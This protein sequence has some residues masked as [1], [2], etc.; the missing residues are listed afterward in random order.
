[1]VVRFP[2]GARIF[3]L[4]SVQTGFGAP[5]QPPIQLPGAHSSDVNRPGREAD[6]SPLSS[7]EVKNIGATPPLVHKSSW[8]SA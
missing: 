8:H 5:T 7:F 6:N 3:L 2:E 4:L 1:M